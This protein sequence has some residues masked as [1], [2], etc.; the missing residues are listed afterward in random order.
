MHDQVLTWFVLQWD[1]K[2][3]DRNLRGDESVVHLRAEINDPQRWHPPS[4]VV[5]QASC[6][7]EAFPHVQM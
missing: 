1:V 3:I 7:Q 6:C 5:M 2:S 4:D